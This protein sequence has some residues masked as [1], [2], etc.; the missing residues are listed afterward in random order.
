MKKKV[1]GIVCGRKNG[2]TERAARI[3]LLAAKECGCDVELINLGDL[4]IKPCIGCGVCSRRLR[5]PL[6]LTPCPQ[7]DDDME[8]LDEQI[9]SSDALLFGAPMYEQSPPA[10][11]KAMCDRFGPSHDVAFIKHIYDAR[12]EAGVDPVYDPRYFNHRPAAF[13]GLGG[14]EWSYMGFPILGIPAICLGLKVVDREQF[15]WNRGI[16]CYED[17]V[18]RMKAMGR[19]LAQMAQLPFDD[20]YYN[21]PEGM[22]PVCHNNVMLMTPGTDECT[23]ALCGMIGK[24]EIKDGKAVAHFTEEAILTSHLTDTGRE[25]HYLD[26][27]GKGKPM[28]GQ[29]K[30]Y[31][32][33]EERSAADAKA[34]EMMKELPT[35]KPPKK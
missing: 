6:N 29:P 8:W 24:M 9:C 35:T 27:L 17:R 16:L 25:I 13:F 1:L 4:T 14:S 34:R 26:L 7:H 10:A 23:C 28:P 3:A 20:T 19:H 12:V 15:N 5:E 11:Y 32:T 2:E 21:G 31:P 30:S 33:P 22:C 18:E